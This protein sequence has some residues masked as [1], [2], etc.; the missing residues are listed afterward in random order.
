MSDL[1][2]VIVTSYNH[3]EY[4]KQRMDSLLTQTYENLEII[5][6]DDCS[7]DN[8][9]E[10][11]AGYKHDPRVRVVSQ[12]R[13]RGYAAA[14]NLAVS[15]CRGEYILFAECDD[16]SE[17][18]QAE[19]LYQKLAANESVGVAFSGS[20]MVDGR[21]EKFRED[22]SLR[23][24]SFQKL[25][26]TD[27]LIPK[28][29]MQKFFL[30][31]CVIPNMSAAMLKKEYFAAVSGLSPLYKACA[32]WD[33]WCRIAPTCDFYYVKEPLNNF[34]RHRNTVGS[35]FNLHQQVNE[36]YA[37]LYAAAAKIKL[38]IIERLTFRINMGFIWSIYITSA[39][40]RWV[41]SFPGILVGTFKYEKLNILFL[42]LG[43]I[44]KGRLVFQRLLN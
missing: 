37:L 20:N 12:E 41:K 39:P 22:F 1:V 32:D 19:I 23:E 10:V 2:S 21:G 40:L 16:Y 13:N 6:V 26:A 24:T 30:I 11:L 17:P 7:T 44:K 25:C 33:F 28:E 34:R 42:L 27:T 4:L 9:L 43:M 35:T 14:N 15:L 38:T 3:A 18:T 36:T 29:T 5:V 8:S 31:A